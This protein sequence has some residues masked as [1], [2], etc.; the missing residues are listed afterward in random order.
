MINFNVIESYLIFIRWC[1]NQCSVN[2]LF[3]TASLIS[4][5]LAFKRQWWSDIVVS[6]HESTSSLSQSRVMSQPQVKSQ[7]F[8]IICFF[9]KGIHFIVTISPCPILIFLAKTRSKVN[10]DRPMAEVVDGH[11]SVH[12]HKLQ[13]VIIPWTCISNWIGS[14]SRAHL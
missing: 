3:T 13:Y 6:Q 2:V 4:I 8:K 10:F 14:P 7:V 1:I 12:S 5:S 11:C 9:T